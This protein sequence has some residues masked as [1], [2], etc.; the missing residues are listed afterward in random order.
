MVGA[1]TTASPHDSDRTPA[2]F[3]DAEAAMSVGLARNAEANNYLD[4]LDQLCQPY[5]GNR[6][7]ELGSGHGD[8]TERFARDG[9]RVDA[10]D[11]SASFLELLSER[12]ADTEN[13]AVAEL[14]VSTLSVED[15]YDSIVMMN[16]L[17]HIEDDADALRRL[18]G[19]LTPSGRLIVY[20]PAF[21]LLYSRFD[22]EIGHYRRYR[23]RPLVDLFERTGFRVVDARYVNSVGALGWFV[24]C[25]MLGRKSSDQL[26][27]SACD[28][29]VVPI[30]R[31]VEQRFPPPFGLSVLVVGERI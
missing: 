25:R 22:R 14:D 24:Y 9:R 31:R 21:M 23:K 18:R 4:W 5:L 28:R 3:D 6:C 7:L 12:F 13:I 1:M 29:V 27:V 17:E 19:A 26:T 10:T 15:E 20:V 8:L 2:A 11:V 30:V 16:V